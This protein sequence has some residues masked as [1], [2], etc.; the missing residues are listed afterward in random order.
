M[1]KLVEQ[2]KKKEHAL[3]QERY[4][5][6]KMQTHQRMGIWVPK[7]HVSSFLKIVDKLQRTKWGAK[8]DKGVSASGS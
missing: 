6:K 4:T 2:E 8:H 5:Q 3:A 7:K 1:I